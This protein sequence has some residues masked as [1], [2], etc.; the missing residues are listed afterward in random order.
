[1]V[2]QHFDNPPAEPEI[3]KAEIRARGLRR[4]GDLADKDRLSADV[5]RNFQTLQQYALARRVFVY[6]HI[7]SEVRT[8]EL[9]RQLLDSR[10]QV[11]VPYCVDDHLQ[12]FRLSDLAELS[13]GTM[14]ILEPKTCFRNTPTRQVDPRELDLLAIP[15]VAFDRA[16]GRVG[17]GGGYFDRFLPRL[18]DDACALGLAFECQLFDRVPMKRHDTPIHGVVTERGVYFANEKTA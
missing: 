2:S 12:L 18:R 4:R 5:R 16:G 3:S 6:L 14:G 17:H 9:V 8:T 15:G 13:P 7:R 11:V 10:K 1:M